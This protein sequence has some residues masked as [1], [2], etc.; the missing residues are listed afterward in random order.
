MDSA[1][2]AVSPTLAV[3]ID[4]ARD[5]VLGS[6]DAPVTL[7]EYGDYECPDCGAAY[8]LLRELQA[9]FP[10]QLLF[11]FRH[12]PL[13][14]IHQHASQAAQAVEEAAVQGKFW[15]M[16]DLLYTNQKHLDL[17]DLTHLALRLGLEIY[18]FEAA[19][20]SGIHRRRVE[21]DY[22]GGL[23]SGVH[24]TPTLFINGNL[25][26][27]PIT[28]EALGAEIQRDLGTPA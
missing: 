2:P 6:R 11:V 10:R 27:G 3:A 7:L 1:H 26:D 28:V 5:H 16:H 18:Q 8:P 14:T 20:S 19:L 17:S 24:K 25:Y 22:Q 21:E 13:F 15:P 9:R 23:R 12:F 4:L